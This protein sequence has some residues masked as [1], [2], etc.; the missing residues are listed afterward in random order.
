[1]PKESKKENKS[2][3]GR[4]VEDLLNGDFFELGKTPTD[5]IKKLSS[6]GFSLKGKQISMVAR[7]LT[8]ECQKSEARIEREE[9]PK[10]KRINQERWMFKK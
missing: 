9:I 2:K 3:I 8:L 1:M 10:E 5:V 4:A 6:K 7:M